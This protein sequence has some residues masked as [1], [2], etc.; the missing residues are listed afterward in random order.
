MLQARKRRAVLAVT[1]VA[2]AALAGCQILAGIDSRSLSTAD[3]AGTTDASQDA[4]TGDVAVDTGEPCTKEGVKECTGSNTRRACRGG[5]W[6]ATSCAGAQPGCSGGECVSSCTSLPLS[7]GS[8]HD[9]CHVE[10]VPSGPLYRSYDGVFF[11]DKSAVANV[12]GFTLDAYEVTV[13]RFAVFLA[14]Y[15]KSIPA[16]GMGKNSND[17]NDTGWDS[18]WVAK[19]PA[20]SDELTTGTS[21]AGPGKAKLR[22]NGQGLD[23]WSKSKGVPGNPLSDL[24]INCVTWYEAYAFCIWDGGRLPTEAE[25]NLAASGG[26]VQQ[27]VYPW[28][29]PGD[30]APP[31][32]TRA[33]FDCNHFTDGGVRA[34]APDAIKT[35]GSYS[36][37]GDGRWFHSDLAG[38]VSEW[39]LDT[40][41]GPQEFLN[42]AGTVETLGSANYFVPCD[43]CSDRR[44]SGLRARRG[45][46]TISVLPLQ[47]QLLPGQ[48]T[49]AVSDRH[50]DLPGE[51]GRSSRLGFRCA[52]RRKQ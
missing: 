7:C 10:E 47:V 15:P 30:A 33:S 41:N 26:A 34:C 22:C 42:E 29:A 50:G 25:W 24:P 37:Q 1:A 48:G 21:D 11:T 49:I 16:A 5:V 46:S 51:N 17:S 44:D 45:G 14:D 31:D 40:F 35:V 38:N 9:C 27:R 3:D 23:T 2:V 43:D 6:N 13:G 19:M 36:P 8:G 18:A 52:G 28:S 20:T 32:E 12:T 39:T 4:T